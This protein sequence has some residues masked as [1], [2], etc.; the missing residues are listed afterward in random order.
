VKW[1]LALIFGIETHKA[2]VELSADI[3]MSNEALAL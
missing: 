2:T 1:A 3:G